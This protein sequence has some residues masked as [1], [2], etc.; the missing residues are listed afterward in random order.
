MLGVCG[1]FTAQWIMDKYLSPTGNKSPQVRRID[2][3]IEEDDSTKR[4]KLGSQSLLLIL[5]L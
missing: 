5:R 2:K 3:N 1:S 4:A